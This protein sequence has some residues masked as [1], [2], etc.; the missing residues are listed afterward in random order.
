MK[1]GC[2]MTRTIL[3]AC[4]LIRCTVGGSATLVWMAFCFWLQ[5]GTA[6]EARRAAGSKNTG[7]RLLAGRSEMAGKVRRLM[8]DP[9]DKVDSRRRLGDLGRTGDLDWGAVGE[10]R[11]IAQDHLLR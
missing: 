3:R 1:L 2:P 10:D 8:T 6:R 11:E 7:Q 9:P 5:P 4:G